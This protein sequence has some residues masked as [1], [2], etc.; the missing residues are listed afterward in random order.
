[1]VKTIVKLIRIFILFCVEM[2]GFSSMV[3][4][5]FILLRWTS[6]HDSQG[7][8]LFIEH[9]CDPVWDD[10]EFKVVNTQPES[11]DMNIRYWRSFKRDWWN[12]AEFWI[13][14]FVILTTINSRALEPVPKCFH[15][16][17]NEEVDVEAT[18]HRFY[19]VSPWKRGFR[20]E[21]DFVLYFSTIP[22][23]KDLT[24]LLK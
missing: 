9:F 13:F 21:H 22:I 6:I 16:K 17:E 10:I 19:S 24:I 1:M 2:V 11:R 23:F 5:E 8:N 12:T 14:R 18:G 7:M 20:I 15:H 3:V 4:I